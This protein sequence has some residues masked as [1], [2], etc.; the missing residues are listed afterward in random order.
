MIPRHQRAVF[1]S[2]FA[3]HRAAASLLR[4]SCSS[5]RLLVGSPCSLAR[6]HFIW[7]DMCDQNGKSSGRISGHSWGA[8][9]PENL[10]SRHRPGTP[11]AREEEPPPAQ[12]TP[13][14]TPRETRQEEGTHL[15]HVHLRPTSHPILWVFFGELFDSAEERLSPF[16][17]RLYPI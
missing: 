15:P 8:V 11:K 17:G 13:P 14:A 3:S 16:W 9:L 12:S 7:P 5:C 4:C 6:C 10:E 2:C 1:T